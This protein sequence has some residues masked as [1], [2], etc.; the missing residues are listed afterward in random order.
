M[1]IQ[2]D[3]MVGICIIIITINKK[4]YVV[5][6]F[7]NIFVQTLLEILFLRDNFS[8]KNYAANGISFW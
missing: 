7:F 6:L 5:I 2:T 1:D 3:I 4:G 8:L